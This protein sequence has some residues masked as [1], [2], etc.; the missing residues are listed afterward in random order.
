MIT[1]FFFRQIYRDSDNRMFGFQRESNMFE[2]SVV[3]KNRPIIEIPPELKLPEPP[4]T[5]AE[6]RDQNKR[7]YLPG[8]RLQIKLNKQLKKDKVKTTSLTETSRVNIDEDDIDRISK[9]LGRVMSSL[10]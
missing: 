5:R 10:V 6:A 9:S 1:T 3:Y 7:R 8:E 4:Q 2:T